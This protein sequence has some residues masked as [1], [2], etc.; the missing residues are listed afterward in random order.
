MRAETKKLID[1]IRSNHP[2]LD[3]KRL[4]KATPAEMEKIKR[5]IPE[6]TDLQFLLR[7]EDMERKS[8][9]KQHLQKK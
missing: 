2:Y 5:M 7:I 6:I 1:E 9:A 3:F 8:R 4:A